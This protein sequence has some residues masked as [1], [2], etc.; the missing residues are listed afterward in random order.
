MRVTNEMLNFPGDYR[1]K[2]YRKGDFGITL[3]K[4]E[5]APERR[6]PGCG[7]KAHADGR[8][9]RTVFHAP[10]STRPLAPKLKVRRL[11]RPLQP[12][13]LPRHLLP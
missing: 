5:A 13:E 8:C 9:E 1:L 11:R 7:G 6:R 4:R 12:P 3:I 2:R 10:V